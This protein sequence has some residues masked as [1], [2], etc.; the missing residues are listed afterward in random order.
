[1]KGCQVRWDA[2]AG[3]LVSL[4]ADAGTQASKCHCSSHL[5]NSVAPSQLRKPAYAL[6]A[7]GAFPTWR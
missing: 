2:D 7:A 4:N 5:A 1:M 3:T 6:Q